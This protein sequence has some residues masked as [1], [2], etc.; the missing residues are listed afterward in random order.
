VLAQN[1]V[2]TAELVSRTIGQEN[3]RRRSVGRQFASR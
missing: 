1:H 3:R 2:D